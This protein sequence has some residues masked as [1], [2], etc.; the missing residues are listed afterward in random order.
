MCVLFIYFCPIK[1]AQNFFFEKK[2]RKNHEKF[3][4]GSLTQT[5][6]KTVRITA[7]LKLQKW[8]WLN[9]STAL[10]QTEWEGFCF[11]LS[12]DDFHLCTAGYQNFAC[13]TTFILST[14]TCI[15][16]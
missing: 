2:D 5:L 11:L 13:G 8:P 3:V 12:S 9:A 16:S 10:Q 7:N 4:G 14:V 6:H 15:F 1:L